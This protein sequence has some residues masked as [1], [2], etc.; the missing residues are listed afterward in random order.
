MAT[1]ERRIK[2][3]SALLLPFFPFF[4]SL[5][6]SLFLCHYH[7]F[8]CSLLSTHNSDSEAVAVAEGSTNR[9]KGRRKDDTGDHHLESPSVS[10]RPSLLFVD[11]E[12][13]GM[14][15]DLARECRVTF[16]FDDHLF[17]K[18]P[19][20]QRG[21][22]RM[23]MGSAVRNPRFST[24]ERHVLAACAAFSSTLLSSR[25]NIPH[26][27]QSVSELASRRWA[28]AIVLFNGACRRTFAPSFLNSAFFAYM[29]VRNTA[30]TGVFTALPSEEEAGHGRSNGRSLGCEGWRWGRRYGL[31]SPRVSPFEW[32]VLAARSAFSGTLLSSCSNIP[33]SAYS[34]TRIGRSRNPSRLSFL[35]L[36]EQISEHS[37]RRNLVSIVVELR[38]CAS[39][40]LKLS[41]PLSTG[42]IRLIP[43]MPPKDDAGGACSPQS[44]CHAKPDPR[45]AFR[46]RFQAAAS[47]YPAAWI[48]SS[49]GTQLGPAS[50]KNF[51]APTRII[52]DAKNQWLKFLPLSSESA[53][54]S[55]DALTTVQFHRLQRTI[56]FKFRVPNF[57]AACYNISC[58]IGVQGKKALTELRSLNGD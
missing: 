28:A 38:H 32:H 20:L 12:D 10:P 23:G 3:I 22:S 33:C 21:P 40:N 27:G 51:W 9:G 52:A 4:P 24:F 18:D 17:V 58:P 11:P 16:I 19:P 44:T 7:Y 6:L 2:L 45:P 25:S 50:G 37:R 55:T 29:G 49:V 57:G 8:R 15:I 30:R 43:T 48:C 56:G 1:A 46:Q 34:M 42:V 31:R 14:Q 5:S 35:R 41:V 47:S 26:S 36:H 13:V 39:T 54:P 53:C